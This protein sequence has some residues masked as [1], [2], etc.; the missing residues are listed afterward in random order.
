MKTSKLG[1]ATLAALTMALGLAVNHLMSKP[2][3]AKLAFGEWSKILAGQINRG[4]YY[5]VVDGKNQIKGFAGW[6]MTSREKAEAWLY[7]NRPLSYEDCLEGKHCVC[8][9][10]SANTNQAHRWM[11][12][13]ARRIWT[14]G[15]LEVIYFKRFYADG[16]VR[17]TCFS[18]NQLPLR[19]P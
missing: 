3:F 15:G 19:A 14:E 4:H 13:E 17:P 10:W 5:F 9:V 6:G 2:A 1:T 16:R 8:N 7:Q 12:R 11:T 18:V